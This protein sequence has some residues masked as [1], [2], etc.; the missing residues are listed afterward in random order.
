MIINIHKLR[1]I[2]LFVYSSPF[3]QF[4]VHKFNELK[5]LAYKQRACFSFAPVFSVLS[6][7]VNL[8]PQ[9]EQSSLESL[10]SA[11]LLMVRK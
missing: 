5:V 3:L 8:T 2:N 4:F 7:S 11:K 10:S 9:N 1:K 6:P